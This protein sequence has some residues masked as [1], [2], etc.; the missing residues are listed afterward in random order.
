MKLVDLT[1]KRFG[2]LT[3]IKRSVSTLK[4][5]Q[6]DCIC[7][8]GNSTSVVGHSLKSGLT[9]SCGC[10]AENN[11]N[12]TTHGLR[13]ETLYHIWC[14]I[15]SRCYNINNPKYHR[16][17]GRGV[18]VCDEWVNDFKL[19]YDWA[20]A[21]GWEDGLQIDK[22][23]KAHKAGIEGLIYSP[24]WCSIVT[25]AENVNYRKHSH[26]ISINGQTKNIMQWCKEYNI[27][28]GTLYSRLKRGYSIEDALTKP[29]KQIAKRP[30]LG[31]AKINYEI[32]DEIRKQKKGGKSN[33]EIAKIYSVDP[34]TISTIVNNKSWI[35]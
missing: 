18:V 16:Y 26:F 32:A 22:D 23:I 8:C 11:L 15:K 31:N 10:L 4:R 17:G 13:H 20:I 7:D 30:R 34:S 6:W 28:Q 33:I 24:E 21:N 3:I 14:H 2:K 27:N 29:V 9:K 25:N 5:P 35:K 12:R 1:G 19:F